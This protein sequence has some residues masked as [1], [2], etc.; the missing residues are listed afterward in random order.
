MLSGGK[1]RI[2]PV[3]NAS[4]PRGM[5]GWDQRVA[6][7]V[8]AGK[9]DLGT[10]P[11]AR[12][13]H[14]GRDEPPGGARTLPRDE[15]RAPRP[16]PRERARR[17]DA[18]RARAGR[19]GRAR[20]PA[21]GAAPSRS[22][23]AQPLLSPGDYSGNRRERAPLEDVLRT[24]RG[25]GRELRRPQRGRVRQAIAGGAVAAAESAFAWAGSLEADTIATANVT[26]FPKVESLVV[27]ADVF[28][29]LDDEQRRILEEAAVQTRDWAIRAMPS[30]AE[31][32]QVLRERRQGGARERRRSRGTEGGCR[33]RV[34]G[35]RAGLRDAFADRWHPCPHGRGLRLGHRAGFLRICRTD[36]AARAAGSRRGGRRA[37]P[38][39]S[40]GSASRSSSSRDAAWTP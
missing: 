16:S 31:A 38:K 26:F 6:R 28:E 30:E 27:D 8:I 12:L 36:T 11:G 10:D 13:G 1:L 15:R 3:W 35:A 14:A 23:T 29:G 22:P 7:K 37:S 17:E 4:G 33:S 19:G 32:L 39:A 21:R 5:R 2:E 25:A 24:L 18:G 40:T 20:T 9:L 34:R